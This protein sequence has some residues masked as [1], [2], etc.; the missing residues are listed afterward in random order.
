MLGDRRAK[1][2]LATVQTPV[3]TLEHDVTLTAD[4]NTLGKRLVGGTSSASD[5]VGNVLHLLGFNL[6]MY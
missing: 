5:D 2:Y 6:Q 4:V 1:T 3:L